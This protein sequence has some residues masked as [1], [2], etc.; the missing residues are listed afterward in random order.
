MVSSPAI[1]APSNGGTRAGPQASN[2]TVPMAVLRSR[3]EMWAQAAGLLATAWLVWTVSAGPLRIGHA[4]GIA[5]CALAWSAAI[6]V[7][8]RHVLRYL[9]AEEADA[10][11]SATA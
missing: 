4:L 1:L 10:A 9:H 6:A 7:L 3:I 2:R 8:L 5:F 11:L